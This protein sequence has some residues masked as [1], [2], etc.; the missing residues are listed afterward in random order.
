MR[1]GQGRADAGQGV[2]V[3]GAGAIQVQGQAQGQEFGAVH[4]GQMVM[5]VGVDLHPA[6]RG[7][8]YR[9]SPAPYPAAPLLGQI[10]A[11]VGTWSK[12]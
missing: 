8:L 6:A 11:R 4:A 12:A 3:G 9:E 7:Q 1:C 5:A 10:S 2:Q